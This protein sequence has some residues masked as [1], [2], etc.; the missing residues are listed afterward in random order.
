MQCVNWLSEELSKETFYQSTIDFRTRRDLG[1]NIFKSSVLKATKW[2]S[3]EPTTS[4]SIEHCWLESESDIWL[5]VY[6]NLYPSF[7]CDIPLIKSM[8]SKLQISESL[9]KIQ[10]TPIYCQYKSLL[11]PHI[12]LPRTQN[13]LR[14]EMSIGNASEAANLGEGSKLEDLPRGK[15]KAEIVNQIGVLSSVCRSV[16]R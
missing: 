13:M 3:E 9:S 12:I 4:Y 8:H 5:Q 1:D 16:R 14:G 6:G 2:I 11:Q 7:I 15:W 10:F